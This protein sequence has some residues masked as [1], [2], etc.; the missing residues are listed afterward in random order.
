LWIR[1]YCPDVYQELIKAGDH[2]T[3]GW[4][5]PKRARKGI[6]VAVRFA[7][8]FGVAKTTP[9]SKVKNAT[10]QKPASRS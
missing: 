1:R 2:Y 7:D 6:G 9:A 5:S 8:V 10:K 3:I 4:D